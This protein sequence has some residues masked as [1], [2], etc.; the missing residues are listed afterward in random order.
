MAVLFPQVAIVG[1]GLIGGSLGMALK[2]H[3]LAETVIGVGR[4]PE[5]LEVGRRLGAI[6]A[7][8]AEKEAMRGADLIVLATPVDSYEG[9]LAAWGQVLKPGALVSDVGSVKGALVAQME[10][11][12][13]PKT[14]F[15]GAHPIAGREKSGVEAGSPTLFQD[16]RC[17]V[18]PTS[19]TDSG[20]LRQVTSL[21]EAVGARVSTMDPFVH[22]EVLGAVSHLPHAVAYALMNTLL[23]LNHRFQPDLDLFA[24]AGGGLRDTTRI[25]ASPPELWREICFY[26][27][28][29][30]IEMLDIFIQKA[31]A[32]KDRLEA[33]DR[34]GFEKEL[35][36]AQRAR[37]LW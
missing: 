10:D 30:L 35:E 14:Y 26:N 23:D 4:N 8:A 25:A 13:P 24:Y 6:D 31:Q 9:Q 7:C 17:I 16:A 28:A 29:N 3:A 2:R 36:R 15:V 19:R 27:R 33:G 37:R 11:L 5:K 18:T 12:M 34:A 32:L 1:V 21:W 20:A 22:D